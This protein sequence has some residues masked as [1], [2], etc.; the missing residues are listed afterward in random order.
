MR[1]KRI[2]PCLDVNA[3][4]V[5]KGKNFEG[6][7]DAG[8]PV[9]LA[10]LYDAAKADELAVL[11]IMATSDNRS[12]MTDIVRKIAAEVS[13]PLTVGGGIRTVE[14]IEKILDSGANKVSLSSAAVKNPSLIAEGVKKFGSQ[15]IVVAIDAKKISR[16][17]FEKALNY[18]NNSRWEVYIDGGRNATGLDVLE[19]A[20]QAVALG[21]GEILLTSVHRDGMK[22][23]Y[24]NDLNRTV[25]E[26]INVP[27]I[28]SG[29]AGELDHFYQALTV[30]K[31][32]AVL[33][34]SVFHYK[35]FTV[36]EVKQYLKSRGVEI[37]L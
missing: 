34:A 21:A 23:G 10:R 35:Q 8:D 19:W 26:K 24:D 16:G 25:A 3:G 27:V 1:T 7:I 18:G 13:I 33:A 22:D 17:V 11:D 14:D 32:D 28:A 5:V 9:E 15:R 31:A 29:G 30:G 20:E 37:L 12:T 36:G 4:R 2:I 6:L